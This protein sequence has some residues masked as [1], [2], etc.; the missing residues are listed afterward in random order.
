VKR[1]FQSAAAFALVV[2]SIIVGTTL[3]RSPA[4]PPQLSI[5][6]LGYTNRIGPHA[7][8]A[9][10]NC[11]TRPIL[12]ESSCLIKYSTAASPGA[13]TANSIDA[14]TFR[15]TRLAPNAGFVQEFFVFPGGQG[16]W[17]FECYAAYGSTWLNAARSM[18]KRFRR[19]FPRIKW[20]FTSKAWRQFRT[21]WRECPP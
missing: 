8:L 18:E 10:T 9:I 14:N 11:S 6:L 2:L 1:I 21:E 3:V 15:L 19:F 7:L 13:R 17:Q 5:D 20:S 12:L 16:E 4:V